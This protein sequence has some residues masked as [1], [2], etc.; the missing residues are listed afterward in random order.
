TNFAEAFREGKAF[1][2]R[3]AGCTRGR[4]LGRVLLDRG[5]RAFLRAF[6]RFGVVLLRR[7]HPHGRGGR[8]LV[9]RFFVARGGLAHQALKGVIHLVVQG[10]ALRLLVFVNRGA[11]TSDVDGKSSRA[12]GGALAL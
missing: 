12:V 5:T 2:G 8:Q 10:V 7:E 9:V 1:F 6:D 3:A 11:R 4:C